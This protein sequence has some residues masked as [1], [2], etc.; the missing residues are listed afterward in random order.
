VTE[1]LGHRGVHLPLDP[2]ERRLLALLDRR[3]VITCEDSWSDPNLATAAELAALTGT[4]PRNWH[5]WRRAGTLPWDRA[6]EI[7]VGIGAHPLEIW[8]EFHEV[9][10]GGAS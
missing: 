1:R 9:I 8:P 6:D 7:A 3:G 5:R 10:D 4:C 2:L